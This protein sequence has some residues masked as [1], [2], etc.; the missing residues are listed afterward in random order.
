MDLLIAASTPG[1][2]VPE[3]RMLRVLFGQQVVPARPRPLDAKGGIV[4]L[5]PALGFLAVEIVALVAE[6]RIVLKDHEPVRKPAQN[7]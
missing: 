1:F 2:D 5:E 4:E 3:R 7:T 6:K